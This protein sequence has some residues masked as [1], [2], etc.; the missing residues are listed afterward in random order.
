MASGNTV[1]SLDN[2]AFVSLL[3]YSSLVLFK[4][5]LMPVII[6]T[7][8]TLSNKFL[9]EEDARALGGKTKEEDIKACLS[10]SPLIDRVGR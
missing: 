1:Y 4:I 3:R 8:R 2:E 5:M 10:Q 9:N 6:A 7:A